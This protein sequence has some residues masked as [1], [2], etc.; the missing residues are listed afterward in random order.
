M[1]RIN[2]CTLATLA[3][4]IGLVLA[5]CS[6]EQ[7]PP[8]K[9]Q[10]EVAVISM[11]P[12]A[13][14]LTSEL[15]GRTKAW[16]SAQIRPQVSGIVKE[17]LFTE[18]SVVK[19][20]EA[21]Y[22]LD[23]AP[24]QATYAQ[25]KASAAEAKATLSSARLK[26]SR[27]SEL[28]KIDAISRQDNEDAQASLQSADAA[29]QAAQA[30]VASARIDLNYTTI[31]SP[32]AGRIEA[33]S[34][35]AGALVTASQDSVLTTVQQIDS[36]YVDITQSS[37]EVLRLKRELAA[38]TLVGA[39]KDGVK[40][41]L[42]LEDG[43]QYAHAGRLQFSGASV[44][45]STGS[46]TLRAV[47]PNPD[48]LL[49]PGMYVR[50]VLTE[51]IDP[52]ALLVPQ[53]AVTRSHSG[54]TSVLVVVDGKVEQRLISIDRNVG[55]QWWVTA[56]LAA[57]DEVIVEGGQKVKIGDTVNSVAAKQSGSPAAVASN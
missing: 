25:S 5:G 43:S 12:Q 51:A 29:Y 48:S 50:A 9:Q 10:A 11:A 13:Q 32:I 24:Y 33:S 40:I 37:A 38:G 16:M 54:A 21:L 4:T 47:V 57:G 49:L 35:T 15:P 3:V 55:N 31:T 44:S 56:G 28:V 18:G 34:V 2:S 22:K 8:Q 17:R 20:G 53:R 52:H 42:L 1:S 36:L 30:S 27:Y 6:P 45:E 26:A 46:V 41:D 23:P 7:T 19:A 14:T 39:D